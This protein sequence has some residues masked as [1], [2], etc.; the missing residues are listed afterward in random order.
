MAKQTLQPQEIIIADGSDNDATE[1]LC[2][3][4]I[5]NL[6][7]KVIYHP[8]TAIGA[9]TQRNQALAYATQNHIWLLDDD[10]ILEPDCLAKLWQ[11][12]QSDSKLG[13]V[14]AM[15]TNQKYLPPGKITSILFRLLHGR[16]ENSYAGKCIGPGLNLLPED[17][18]ELPEVVTVEWLNSGCTLYRREALPEPL[19]P[20]VFIGY[21]LMEDLSLSLTVGKRWKLANAR[22]AR[23][24]HD[25]QPGE[26][27]NNPGVLA[28]MD[29]VN[30][31][32]VMTTVLNRATLQ[33]YFKLTILQLFGIAT[34]LISLRGWLNLPAILWGKIIAIAE[35]IN[36][37][38]ETLEPGAANK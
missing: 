7:S 1:Q 22:T 12:L 37:D 10:I 14:N 8:A 18:P 15:I 9:A 5:S 23:I 4:E 33:D 31:H 36:S 20:P 27:K 11:A 35:I 2:S 3:S 24:F 32:Y 16:C 6:T 28:K 29:L 26:D 38:Y 21:S 30:R 34:S 13:G 19:F 25:S 17:N